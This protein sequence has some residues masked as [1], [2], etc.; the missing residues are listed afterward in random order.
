MYI[1]TH[2]H[3]T[4]SNFDEDRAMAIGNAKKAGVKLFINPGVDLP[5]SRQA[6]DLA[7]KNPDVVFA[8]VGFHPYEAQTTQEVSSLAPLIKTAVAIGECGLDYH[9]YKGEDAQGKKQK[10]RILF[11]EQLRL[12]LAHNL[13]VIMHC[14]DAYGDFFSVLDS[15]PSRPRGVIHCFSGGLQELRE[16]TKRKLFVGIDGNVTYSKQLA[17]IVP[18]IP[19]SMLLLETDSPYLTPVPHRGE[20]NEPKYIP[21]VAQKIAELQNTSVK[22]VEETTTRNAQNLFHLPSL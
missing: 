5:S 14:R 22:T 2:C 15:L 8:A 1:D 16:A 4:F 7:Q 13:P 19:L 21:L 20:R 3:L 18:H 11:E 6:V 17:L 10:Q 12:A 9:Q